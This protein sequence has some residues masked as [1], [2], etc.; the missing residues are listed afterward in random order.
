MIL[1]AAAAGCGSSDQPIGDSTTSSTT[2]AQSTTTT[3]S[4]REVTAQVAG[5]ALTGHCTGTQ[6]DLPAVV[7]DSGMAGGQQELANLEEQLSQ[8]TVYVPTIGREWATAIHL[9]RLHGR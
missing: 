5:R 1:V 2:T 3:S 7:L 8:R 9:P 6:Q 4:V